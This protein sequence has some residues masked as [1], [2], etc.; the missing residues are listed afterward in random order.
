VTALTREQQIADALKVL[1]P[2]PIQH[3][4]LKIRGAVEQVLDKIK[5]DVADAQQLRLAR[6][7]DGKKRLARYLKSVR[8]MQSAFDALELA[9]KPYLAETLTFVE[10]VMPKAKALARARPTKRQRVQEDGART[11]DL[12]RAATEEAY[13]LLVWCG[14]GEPAATLGG[15]WWEKLTQAL[16]GDDEANVHDH[17]VTCK[18]SA[19]RLASRRLSPAKAGR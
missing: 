16:V 19:P 10:R 17:L 4:E 13:V 15:P 18:K 8:E 11:T 1:L 5:R 14:H 3:D 6:S 2:A 9:D 12:K 7:E